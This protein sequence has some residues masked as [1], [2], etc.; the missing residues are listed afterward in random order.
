MAFLLLSSPALA[1]DPP[2]SQVDPET[3]LIHTVDS[4]ASGGHDVIRH[5][6]DA[7]QGPAV[8]GEISGG[9]AD[10]SPHLAIDDDSDVHVAWQRDLTLDQIRVVV[11]RPNGTLGTERLASDPDEDS[12]NP[13]LVLFGIP[14]LV[15]EIHGGDGVAV[16]AQP[17]LDEPDPLGAR[18]L[19]GTS[20]FSGD[21]DA[22]IHAAGGHLWATWV[23]AT[24]SLGFSVFDPAEQ[25]WSDPQF[26]DV[27]DEN[28]QAAREAVEAAVSGP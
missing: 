10:F 25:K 5:I 27:V 14:Y 19:L 26:E 6:V 17:V 8:S 18:T 12:R 11:V 22:R 20:G 24:D 13:D 4:A 21:V 28:F 23:D 2:D 1:W 7:G 15:Y 9:N 3:G 16:A